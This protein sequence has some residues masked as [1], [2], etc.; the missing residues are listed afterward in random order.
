VKGDQ[1]H[2]IYKTIAQYMEIVKEVFNKDY[3]FS[4]N[5]E[6]NKNSANEIMEEIENYIIKKLHKK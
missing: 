5:Q 6:D 1:N 4:S 2:K 3:I